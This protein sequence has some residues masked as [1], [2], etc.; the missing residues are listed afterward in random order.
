[1]RFNLGTFVLQLINFF[2]L[3]FI[4]KRLLY[5]PVREMLEK[6]R[7]ME[8]MAMAE[9]EKIRL[10]AR[11]VTEEYEVKRAEMETDRVKILE[12]AEEEAEEKRK[13]ILKKAEEDATTVFEKGVAKLDRERNNAAS[14]IKEEIIKISLAYSS[15]VLSG[16]SDENLH[17][18]ILEKLVEMTPEIAGEARRAAKAADGAV[19]AEIVSAYPVPEPLLSRIRKEFESVP[20]K[21]AVVSAS[22][23]RTLI[24]G[25]VMKVFDKSYDASLKGNLAAFGQ[26]LKGEL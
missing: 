26:K 2:V 16:L 6:R 7:E 1:M 20:L 4:L 8:K 11:A 18:R 22:V 10:E 15:A 9:A 12:G 23:D 5:K 21:N 3:L 14:E 13:A 17:N 19:T 24:A 25:A